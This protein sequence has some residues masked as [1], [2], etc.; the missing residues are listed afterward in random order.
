MTK[1]R[2]PVSTS[3]AVVGAI[4]GWNLFSGSLTDYGS[5]TRIVSSWVLCPVLAGL[6]AVLLLKL[7]DVGTR[8]FRPHL[9]RLD[10][11]TRYGL[12]L[13]GAFASYS[14]GA[15]NIANVMGVFVPV[16]PFADL[17]VLGLFKLSGTQQLFLL[18]GLAI[19][20]GVFT[21]SKRVMLTVGSDLFRL[22]PISALVVVAAQAIV[23]FLFSSESLESWLAS[24]SLPTVPLVPVSSSQ[25]VI[26]AVIGIGLAKGGRNI[27]FR[28][29]ARIASGWISTPIVAGAVGFVLLFFVQ[30]VFSQQVFVP[31]AHVLSPEVAAVLRREGRYDER[32]V[33]LLDR[34][35]DDAAAMKAALAQEV[36]GLPQP[37]VVID[38]ARLQPLVVDV[39]ALEPY[40]DYSWFTEDE[41][42]AVFRLHGRRFR[43]DWQ[44]GAA[45]E[46]RSGEWA[47]L[48]ATKANKAHNKA[49]QEKLSYLHKLF[50]APP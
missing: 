13:V 18:G 50:A 26:G 35:F 36:P 3:Q 6:F 37:E 16:A 19:G 34:R 33:A 20:A 45:L 24:R 29:L 22:S 30:N 15:N 9:F 43:H 28:V 2:L 41:L 10:M 47:P 17:Q 39:E 44:L 4:I 31:V 23:L 21:Y 5:L 40:F 27:D 49:R 42:H 32:M 7:A 14:L 8:V 25:A 12:L 11:G 48:P 1:A 46:A 38:R